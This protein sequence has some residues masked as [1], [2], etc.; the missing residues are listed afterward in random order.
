MARFQTTLVLL[1]TMG[2]FSETLCSFMLE[3]EVGESVTIWCQHGQTV[4]TFIL[5]F[6]HTTDS[7]PLLVG[8]KK[9]RTL[10]PSENCYFYKDTERLVMS[11]QPETTSLTITALNVS[12]TGLYY[13]SSMAMSKLSFRN[14]TY[15]H[16]KGVNKTQVTENKVAGYSCSSVI[17][18]LN[19]V[20]GSVVGILLG[21]LI[22]ILL[23]HRNTHGG[24]EA[25][26]K[27]GDS[28]MMHYSALQFSTKKTIRTKKHN[29]KTETHVVYYLVAQKT[30][31]Q[32]FT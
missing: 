15:L 8:C 28:D 14:S 9:F 22:F 17:F 4:T 26:N 30:D 10:T 32:F 7:V 11:V 31:H 18:M 27:V 1:C 19:T 5:W 23:K 3:A 25:E 16:V 29:E 2:L 20:F 12:D 6:K 24:V 13:C 21:V